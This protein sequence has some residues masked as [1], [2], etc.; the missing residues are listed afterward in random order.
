MSGGNNPVRN[1][2]QG[3]D[4]NIPESTLT[5]RIGETNF[6]AYPELVSSLS[7]YADLNNSRLSANEIKDKNAPLVEKILTN[8]TVLD[9][10]SALQE[11]NFYI[12]AFPEIKA[13]HDF[14]GINPNSPCKLKSPYNK[15]NTEFGPFDGVGLQLTWEAYVVETLGMSLVHGGCRRDGK[16]LSVQDIRGMIT[17]TLLGRANKPHHIMLQKA[18]EALFNPN[19]DPDLRL[20]DSIDSNTLIPIGIHAGP[21]RDIIFKHSGLTQ[22]NYDGVTIS[23]YP[24]VLAEGPSLLEG[25]RV[26]EAPQGKI[27]TFEPW[28]NLARTLSHTANAMVGTFEKDG[29]KGH[30]IFASPLDRQLATNQAALYGVNKLGIALSENNKVIW[31]ADIE[32]LPN[33]ATFLTDHMTEVVWREAMTAIELC[34]VINPDQFKDATYTAQYADQ[35]HNYLNMLIEWRIKGEGE[36]EICGKHLDLSDFLA[37]QG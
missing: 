6:L 22:I 13:I 36:F 15:A 7:A 27:V 9:R 10:N 11:Y 1:Q 19:S 30:G 3:L 4:N 12:E 23:Y 24:A 26:I 28:D 32:N 25:Y 16:D 2:G 8:T 20:I 37:D 35:A 17:N 21:K 5:A 33:R 31:G 18:A 14:F 29:V 34:R